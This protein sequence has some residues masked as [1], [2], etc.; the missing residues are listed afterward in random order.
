M[1]LS[2]VASYADKVN[3]F[4]KRIRDKKSHTEVDGLDEEQFERKIKLNLVY[5]K[6]K[7]INQTHRRLGALLSYYHHCLS[8]LATS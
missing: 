8:F 5:F 7:L 6:F 3:N 1:T 2:S 4:Y